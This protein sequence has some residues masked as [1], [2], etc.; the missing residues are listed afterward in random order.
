MRLS[1]LDLQ[2][3]ALSTT[4][5]RALCE[6]APYYEALT[7]EP[8]DLRV[9]Y[10]LPHYH[11]LGKRFTIG[12]L[13]EGGGSEAFYQLDG[14][15]AGP[16]GRTYDP[17]I[18][19]SDASGLYFT[20]DYENFRSEDVGWGIGDQEMCVALLLVEADV[21]LEMT[22]P[23][24]DGV[25]TI[26]DDLVRYLSGSCLVVGAPK[27][28]QQAPPTRE[29]IEAPLYVPPVDPADA[30]VPPV[31]ACVDVPDAVE[32]IDDTSLESLRTSLFAP[33]CSFAACHGAAASAGLDFT[34]EDLQ[35]ELLEH[36]PVTSGGMP[37]VT[38]GNAQDSWLHRV[39]ADCEPMR[40]DGTIAS[41]MPL[42]APVLLDPALVNGVREWINAGAQP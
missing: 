33:A 37:L 25:V 17:P 24:T 35:A 1:F 36:E 28:A 34:A 7:G 40:L 23:I 16:N 19:L 12:K 9:H 20:C 22:V 32:A 14:F 41:H 6:V 8:W 18:D 38:P 2:I 27:G 3:E 15:D 11:A 5:H 21:I 26:D 39:L 30:D 31:P 29:E 10:A 42:D 4:S 13:F